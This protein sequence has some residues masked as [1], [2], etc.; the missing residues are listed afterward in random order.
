MKLA[1]LLAEEMATFSKLVE[2]VLN[3][4]KAIT[5]HA[6]IKLSGSLGN[7]YLKG[8]LIPENRLSK[9][10]DSDDDSAMAQKVR[11]KITLRWEADSHGSVVNYID[12]DEGSEDAEISITKQNLKSW[13]G[14]ALDGGIMNVFFIELK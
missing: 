8:K 7:I 1:Q 4:D 11:E 9:L 10:V 12:D 14:K 2:A 13:S 5:A 3:L 6:L